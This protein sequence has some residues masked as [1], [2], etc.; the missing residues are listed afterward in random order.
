MSKYD[1]LWKYIQENG[2]DTLKLTFDQIQDILNIEARA[3]TLHREEL[4]DYKITPKGMLQIYLK[5]DI[6]TETL[7]R[8]F[9]ETLG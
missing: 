5:Q 2:G 7:K 1:P 6:P 3:V 4:A 9:A 8:I